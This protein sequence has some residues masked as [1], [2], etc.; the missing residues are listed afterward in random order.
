MPN[1]YDLATPPTLTAE[2]QTAAHQAFAQAVIDELILGGLA[3]T[4]AQTR[5]RGLADRITV[6]SR[7]G[8][9]EAQYRNEFGGLS[10]PKLMAKSIRAAL[11]REAFGPDP[12]ALVTQRLTALGYTGE[13]DARVRGRIVRLDDG[14]VEA[15]RADGVA[16]DFTRSSDSAPAV[17]FVTRA[18]VAELKAEA[19]AQ[20]LAPVVDAKRVDVG[21]MLRGV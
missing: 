4:V 9:P 12:V 19:A 20:A 21:R 5:V 6:T 16:D 3:P 14:R 18:I 17:E 10:N 11:A 1:K 8:G 15:R 7:H 2:Q 13:L